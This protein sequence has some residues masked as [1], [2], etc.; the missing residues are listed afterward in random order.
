MYIYTQFMCKY[1]KDW[2]E[3]FLILIILLL[4]KKSSESFLLNFWMLRFGFKFKKKI[5][6]CY[7]L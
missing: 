3:V 6:Q 7:K 2:L 4:T 1:I 5:K